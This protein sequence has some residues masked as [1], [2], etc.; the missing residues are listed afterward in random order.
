M[1][2]QRT[3]TRDGSC[4]KESNMPTLIE[5]LKSS[6]IP[7]SEEI[8]R[9]RLTYSRI[10]KRHQRPMD[11]DIQKLGE[12]MSVLRLDEAVRRTTIRSRR[13]SDIP[14][15]YQI[16]EHR[17]AKPRQIAGQH[18]PR[19]LRMLPVS[20]QDTA[21]RPEIRRLIGDHREPAAQFI[22]DL[23]HTDRHIGFFNH[24]PQ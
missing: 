9:L 2:Q 11:G 6:S 21:G 20:R 17:F 16:P 3:D 7:P 10:I 15:L 18:Q 14:G 12:C 5:Q 13:S 24:E 22:V 19:S 1:M 8:G 4:R 23:I